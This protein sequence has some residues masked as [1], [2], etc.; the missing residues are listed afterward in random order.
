MQ[1]D[2]SFAIPQQLRAEALVFEGGCVTISRSGCAST[3]GWPTR[4]PKSSWSWR[5]RRKLS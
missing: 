1:P 5:S 3:P 4:Q 2:T